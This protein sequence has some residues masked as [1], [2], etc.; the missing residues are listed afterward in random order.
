MSKTRPIGVSVDVVVV[1]VVV[2]VGVVFVVSVGVVFV[3][4]VGVVAYRW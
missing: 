1:S 2:S 4:S 3:V